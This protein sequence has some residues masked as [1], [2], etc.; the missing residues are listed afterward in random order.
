V[1]KAKAGKKAGK[2][3]WEKLRA[4]RKS[5][6]KPSEEEKQDVAKQWSNADL[7][8]PDGK[9]RMT[10]RF[11]SD[12]VEWFKSYGPRYQTRMNAVLRQFMMKQQQGTSDVSLS[13][14]EEPSAYL[15][16]GD[17]TCAE[18]MTAL[19]ELG[20]IRTQQGDLDA[21]AKCHQEALEFFR[22]KHK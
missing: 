6:E 15:M 14:R 17:Q 5:A 11:D 7:V 8:V 19:N 13:V 10:V 12:V 1:S 20:K 18:Y 21:A 22:G 2:T 3:D 9:T 4:Q 16:P